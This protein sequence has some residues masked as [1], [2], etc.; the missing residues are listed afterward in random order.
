MLTKR[1]DSEPLA[2]IEVCRFVDFK[3]THMIKITVGSCQLCKPVSMH[4]RNMK[5]SFVSSP[6]LLRTSA[7]VCT[8]S[9]VNTRI[10]MFIWEILLTSS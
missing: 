9:E 10:V 4:T 5:E 7:L 3:L 6:T 1:V 8:I 2:F